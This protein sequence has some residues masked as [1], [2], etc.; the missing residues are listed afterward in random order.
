[1]DYEF[2]LDEYDRPVAIFSSGC[3]ALGRWFTEELT[4]HALIEELLGIAE[5]LEQRRIQ[6]RQLFGNDSQLDIDQDEVI[7]TASALGSDA[8]E[9]IPEGTR[10]YDDEAQ[11]SCGLQ[12]FKQALL[13]W[14]AFVV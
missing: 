1:M 8:H 9:E 11:A 3:E 4:N 6:R 2:T 7:I 13:A 12:D 5:Q 10:L 14:Q